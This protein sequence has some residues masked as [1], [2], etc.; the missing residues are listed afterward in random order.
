MGKVKLEPQ[1]DPWIRELCRILRDI[2]YEQATRDHSGSEWGTRVM[3][4]L[5]KLEDAWNRR[6]SRGRLDRGEKEGD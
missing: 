5:D 4:D 2:V 3:S 1:R 6:R